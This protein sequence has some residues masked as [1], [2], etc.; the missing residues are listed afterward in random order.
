M[1]GKRNFGNNWPHPLSGFSSK[2][3]SAIVESPIKKILGLLSGIPNPNKQRMN[4]KLTVFFMEAIDL[5]EVEKI[6]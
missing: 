6:K 2:G 3:L 4:R 1:P 5:K